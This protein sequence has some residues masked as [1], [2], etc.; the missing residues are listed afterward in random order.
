MKLSADKKSAPTITRVSDDVVRIVWM[1][2]SGRIDDL[3]RY[4]ERVVPNWQEVDAQLAERIQE[5]LNQPA[6]ALNVVRRVASEP[7]A[8]GL[9]PIAQAAETT[10]L[11]RIETVIEL[12]VEPV[13]PDELKAGLEGL[14]KERRAAD[15][16]AKA[17]LTATRTVI[18]TGPPGVGK[19]LAARWIARELNLP[20]FVLNLGTV[21]SSFLGRTGTNLRQVMHHA[22]AA[23]CVLFLDEIDAIAK[24]RDDNTDVGEL[25]R[26]VTVLLQELDAWPASGLLL[27]ATNHEDLLD[28]AVWRRFERRVI[29]PLPSPE[30]HAELFGRLL[31]ASWNSLPSDLNRKVTL[32]AIGLTPS[33]IT[34]I[35]MRAKRE[36]VLNEG[37]LAEM[38][39]KHT[40]D[41]VHGLP[42]ARRRQIGQQLKRAGLGQREICR[43]TGLA[44]ETIRSFDS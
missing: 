10:D 22:A 13:W 43:L 5:L 36:A 31:G 33:D 20:L 26:L 19:S 8:I 17:G 32:A 21:M 39:V 28:P 42:L 24:R 15:R 7:P 12:P 40:G 30:Q 2:L 29:F 6:A 16:L 3:R 11:L 41:A 44:R 37:D 1:A 27:A 9:R 23:N 38:L 18:L 35:A 4:L 25:K 14:I 34:Q